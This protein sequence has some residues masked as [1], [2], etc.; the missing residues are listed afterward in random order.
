MLEV[1][2]P[3]CQRRHPWMYFHHQLLL[4]RRLPAQ[5]IMEVEEFHLKKI[6]RLKTLQMPQH[7]QEQHSGNTKE[8][9]VDLMIMES[10]IRQERCPPDS[11]GD[12]A[13]RMNK[14]ICFARL[15]TYRPPGALIIFSSYIEQDQYL[16]SRLKLELIFEFGGEFVRTNINRPLH[17]T[18][19]ES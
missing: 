4:L 3:A 17:E 1:K 2:E 9:E 6:G 18:F 11:C 7:F 15:Q 13:P 5:T 16:I 19:I 8:Q 10:R 14:Q 12:F